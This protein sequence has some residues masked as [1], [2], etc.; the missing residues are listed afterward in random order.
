MHDRH[1]QHQPDRRRPPDPLGQQQDEAGAC[2]RDD[3]VLDR[4][5]VEVPGVLDDRV[6][7]RA[8]AA[9]MGQECVPGNDLGLLQH[10]EKL[11]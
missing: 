8:F 9:L 5:V 7:Q 2:Q 1:D 6:E 11:R 10:A 3:D 4:V